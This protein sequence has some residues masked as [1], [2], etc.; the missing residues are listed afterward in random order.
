VSTFTPFDEG[1]T[2]TSFRTNAYPTMAIDGT[3][4]VYIAYSARN[5]VP[6][7]DARIVLSNSPGGVGWTTPILVDNPATDPLTNPSGRGHQIMPALTFA[8]GRLSL[9]YYDLRLDHTFGLFSPLMPQGVPTGLYSEALQL[10][11]ELNPAT[12]SISAVFNQFVDDSTI[13]LRRHT[14]DLRVA[15]ALPGN[16]PVFAPSVLVSQWML[17]DKSDG[18]RTAAVQRSE[19]PHLSLGHGAVYGRLCGHRGFAILPAAE[20]DREPGYGRGRR[21]RGRLEI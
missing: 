16:P 21:G 20:R 5:T 9:L 12:L 15:Q 17:R 10:A 1:T 4:R 7:G 19:S 14:F 2:S 6:S 13:A 18:Y 3:G 8:A 11:G